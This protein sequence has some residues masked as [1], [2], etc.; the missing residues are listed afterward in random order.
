MKLKICE[1]WRAFLTAQALPLTSLRYLRLAFL[2]LG[3]GAHPLWKTC[4]SSPSAVRAATVQAKMLS[5]RYRS[6]WLRRHWSGESGECRLPG[7]GMVP[8]DV[9]H[10]LSAECPALQQS[11]A[12]TFCHIKSLLEPHPLLLSLL[13]SARN[14]DRESVTM[15]FLD[16]STEPQVIKLCQLYGRASVLDPLFQV[17]RAWIW[18][19][20]RARMRL[21]GLEQYLV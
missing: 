4:K 11:L 19:A 2:P 12:S 8:G 7:C 17:S 3:R 9:A 20:H 10:L 21:L 16:P 5:G 6:C 14:G 1:Y 15:F 18:A 13:L